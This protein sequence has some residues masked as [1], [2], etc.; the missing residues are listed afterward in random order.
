MLVHSKDK[1]DAFY[2]DLL[3]F[4]P[5]WHG[6]MQPDKTD[7][8]SGNAGGRRLAGVHDDQRTVRQ[9]DSGRDFAE[10]LGVLD[11]FLWAW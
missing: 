8:V 2:R 3:G 10:Q 9:R 7:W 6:G 11:H 5:Y 1:E 4:R